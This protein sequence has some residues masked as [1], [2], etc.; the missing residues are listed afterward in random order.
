MPTQSGLSQLATAYDA[1]LCDVWGVVHN[2]IEPFPSAVEALVN[3]RAHGGHVVF[4]TNAPRP[5]GEIVDM[6]DHMGVPR[7]AWDAMASS[8]D[9]SR[10]LIAPYKGKV[11]HHVGPATADDALYEGL[12]VIRGRAEDAEVVVVTDLDSDDETPDDYAAR[13][14]LWL[15]RGLPMICANPDKI[16][17]HGDQ[18]IYCGGALGDYYAERGGQVQ[19]AGKP[20]TPIYDEAM[21][22]AEQSAGRKLDKSRVLAIG[23]SVR[24]DATGAANFGIDLL[25]VTGSIHAADFVDGADSA[26]VEA[27]VAPSGARLAAF[28]PRLAW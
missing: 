19:M 21:R 23:D 15:K 12:G 17:E 8:G 11:I 24:T 27:L 7:S 28:L 26:S 14:R 6:L 4:I 22:L 20:F 9:A 3:Y 13:V 5:S 18:L 25:F 2:G 16:V 1:L 10:T